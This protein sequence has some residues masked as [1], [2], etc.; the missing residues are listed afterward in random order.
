MPIL[1]QN[2][3][4][5]ITQGSIS[6]WS[7][8]W[9]SAWATI[10][11]NLIVQDNSSYPAIVSDLWL[12]GQKAWNHELIDSLFLQRTADAIKR[13]PIIDA[14]DPDIL[15]WKLTPNGRCTTRSTYS[16][17][18]Q[19]LQDEGEP[20]PASVSQDLVQLLNHVWKN[21]L[22]A[23]RVQAFTWR[24]LR[25]ALPSGARAGKYSKQISSLCS[26]CG[27]YEDD[28]HL[29]FLCLFARSAWFLPPGYIRT[30]IFANNCSSIT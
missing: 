24:V 16:A 3:F 23:P 8:P 15:C 12:P 4:Y 9:C 7:T 28:V 25:T 18:L 1:W 19:R 26:R 29:F 6:I 22:L 14:T 20:T 13:T 11:D 27:Q 21:E 5:Q 17:C 2:S 10:Y 30:Y